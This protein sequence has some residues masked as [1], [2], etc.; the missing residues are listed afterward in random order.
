MIKKLQHRFIRITLLALTL[1]MVLAVAVVNVANLFAVR[2]ELMNTVRLIADTDWIQGEN[3]LLTPGGPGGSGGGPGGGQDGE[4]LPTATGGATEAG[5]ERETPPSPRNPAD[6]GTPP[7]LPGENG[8]AQGAGGAGTPPPPPG[9]NGGGPGASGE[10]THPPLLGENGG[11]PGPMERDLHSRNLINESAWFSL[12]QGK[13]GTLELLDRRLVS[14]SDESDFLSLGEQ[15]AKSGADAGFIGDYA[16]TR[17]ERPEGSKLMVFLNGETRMAA[18]RSLAVISGFA[19]VGGILLAFVVT[20]LASRRAVQ[21]TLR[22]MEQQKQFITNASHELK[23]PIT[24]I[25]TNM[26]LLQM[27]IP[28][29]Q[30]VRSTQKQ[31]G[32]LKKL[33]DELVYLSRMEEENPPMTIEKLLLADIV[34]ETAE[35]FAAMA[36][37]AGREMRIE[38]EKGLSIQGDRAS[39]QR[40]ISTLCDNAVKYAAGDGEI[41]V[42][43]RGEGKNAVI[44]VSNPV[45][46][47]LTREQCDQLFNRFYRTDESRNKEKKG[48][49]GIG[50]AIAAAIAENH[51]GSIRAAMEEGGR[52]SIACTLPRGQHDRR[53]LTFTEEEHG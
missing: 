51:G 15:A 52:L 46:E 17:K 1:A 23:T 4:T 16:W 22:N 14:E 26:S 10:G 45:A 32:I 36:E 21:P 25:G 49:F 2:R 33:V 42:S 18:V 20:A 11:E 9:E 6:G 38:A 7:P 31:T 47:P 24:V 37:Y 3:G 30:W 19:C 29:N 28:D 12:L 43:A 27:E 53:E 13:D 35:P 39:M 34:E 8:G 44:T 41:L 5:D 50:L 48:G 40:L